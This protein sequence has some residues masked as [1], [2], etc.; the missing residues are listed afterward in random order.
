MADFLLSQTDYIAFFYGTSLVILGAACFVIRGREG[1]ELPWFFLGAFGLIHGCHEWLDMLKPLA[2]ESSLFAACDSALV[3][4]SF[5]FLCEFGRS[6]ILHLQGKAPG[7][8]IYIPLLVLCFLGGPGAGWSGI[9]DAARYVFGLPG[10]LL[11]AAVLVLSSRRHTAS[12]RYLLMACGLMMILYTLAGVSQLSEISSGGASSAGNDLFLRRW[13]LPSALLRGVFGFGMAFA[14]SLYSH[15]SIR[16]D[17]SLRSLANRS[18]YIF[19]I[20]ILAMVLIITT[21]WLATNY[22]GDKAGEELKNVAKSHAETLE[23]QVQSLLTATDQDVMAMSETPGMS[24]AIA[25]GGKDVKGAA[26]TLHYYKW[27]R[28]SELCYLLDAKGEVVAS[29]NHDTSGNIVGRNFASH[30]YVKQCLSGVTGSYLAYGQATE[31]RGY[32]SGFPVYNGQHE[33]IGVAVIKKSL[34]ALEVDFGR[35]PGLA[36]LVSPEGIIFLS[37]YSDM[38]LMSLWPL[39]NR[40]R[41]QLAASLQFGAG[42]FTALLPK[43]PKNGRTILFNDKSYIVTRQMIDQKGWSIV[44]LSSNAPVVLNRFFGIIATLS[45]C[46]LTIAFFVGT[47]RSLELTAHIA[48]SE[49]RFRLVFEGAP[50]AIFIIDRDTRQILSVNPFMIEWLGYIEKEILCLTMDDI[51]V[52]EEAEGR[53]RRYRKR[54]GA[55]VHV[56]EVRKHITFYDREAILII[57]HDISEHKKAEEQL[58]NLSMSDGLTGIAN[59]RCFDEFLDQEWRRAMRE[60]MPLSLVMGDIDF[61]KNYNDACGHQEGDDCLRRIAHVIRDSLHRPG[62]MAARYG[63]EEFAVIM[64]GTESPGALILAES[65]R[66]QVEARALPHRKSSVSGVVTLSMGVATIVPVPGSAPAELILAADQALYRAKM[67]GRNCVRHQ[68]CL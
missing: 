16:R 30:P 19:L 33:I 43:Q 63:G 14:I 52:K 42:P 37:S 9:A 15:Q 5:L 38:N 49:Q 25:T 6:G 50:G 46:I 65:M 60:G 67:D 57:A 44:L 51:Q 10:E 11:A 8:W 61:F 39:N 55:L 53:E 47:E 35:Q 36:F 7:R 3:I 27:V 29:S 12:V 48:V 17:V 20:S 4:V 58:Y 66:S 32:F 31:R 45:L 18:K 23:S 41:R 40:T 64:A 28:A 56:E 22:L 26:A 21:G 34:D 68:P 24:Q 59:R 54:D 62:D 1:D 13:G 2:R